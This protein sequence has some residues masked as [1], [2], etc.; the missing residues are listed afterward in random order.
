MTEWIGGLGAKQL[1]SQSGCS[2]CRH[3]EKSEQFD[4]IGVQAS[5]EDYLRFSVRLWAGAC[6]LSPVP[7]GAGLD[8]LGKP[9]TITMR[10]KSIALGVSHL[11]GSFGILKVLHITKKEVACFVET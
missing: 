8:F 1:R 5:G 2:G 9:A 10:L 4:K 6:L 11:G 7:S 3:R